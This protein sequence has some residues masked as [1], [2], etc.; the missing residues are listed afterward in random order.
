MK[1]LV[2]V[3]LSLAA[4]VLGAAKSAQASP[5]LNFAP[6]ALK[7]LSPT[8][9][10]ELLPAPTQIDGRGTLKRDMPTKQKEDSPQPPPP[11]AEPVKPARVAVEFQPSPRLAPQRSTQ[12]SINPAPAKLP[13]LIEPAPVD[14]A[15]RRSI[16]L[17]P[18]QLFEGG[19]NSLVATAVGSAEGTRT[20]DGGKT[21]A[22]YGHVDPGNAVWNLGSFSYQH[23]ARSPEE[24]DARQLSRLRQQFE[25]I[26]QTAERNGVQL[27]LEEQLNAID[28]ANQAPLAALAQG[29]YVER[30]RQAQTEG[31][32][33]T[34]AVLR[35][36]T[37]A[38]INPA[39]NR[40]DAPG[41]GNTESSISRDQ[42][43]RL[44]AIA[45]AL[46]VHP[47]ARQPAASAAPREN[48]SPSK[49]NLPEPN[50]SPSEPDATMSSLASEH[51]LRQQK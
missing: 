17:S 12:N 50:L 1:R 9:R 41:L 31:F 19:S 44:D 27:S 7:T 48:A 23:G 21:W 46:S 32:R 20:P 24:A 26:R 8:P 15:P 6:P 51:R 47:V 35:A 34:D 42:A 14:S 13:R 39:T 40:W 37:Y 22:Y 11:V 25:V 36:R 3:A 45:Q 2:C 28:L 18:D 49:P 16:L 38:Y 10:P 5:G 43:R 33:G 4:L 29:G 30:L